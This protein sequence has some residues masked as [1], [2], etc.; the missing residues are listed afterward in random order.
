M[1]KI[2][3]NSPIQV[4]ELAVETH[5]LA[6]VGVSG[7]RLLV[8]SQGDGV[9][10]SDYSLSGGIT[11]G[12][13]LEDPGME[14]HFVQAL[15]G[16]RY[17]LVSAFSEEQEKN[18]FIYNHRGRLLSSFHVGDAIEDVQAVGDHFWIGYMEEGV[19]GDNPLSREGVVCF[20]TKG[21]L[22]FSYLATA[23]KQGLPEVRDCYGLNASANGETWIY[24]F[25]DHILARVEDFRVRQFWKGGPVLS[26]RSPLVQA[27][28]FALW[29]RRLLFGTPRRHLYRGSLIRR[30][31]ERVMPVNKEG[32]EIKFERWWTRDSRLFLSVGEEVYFYDMKEMID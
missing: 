27:G 16:D 23:I 26:W 29:K 31:L 28:G 4:P 8:L 20:N 14:I 17:L 6:R 9:L 19:E 24:Y 15:T 13:R 7:D 5:P 3:M 11:S 25:T 18:A 30:A 2:V 12:I 32:E 10:L 1:D 22:L 21:K